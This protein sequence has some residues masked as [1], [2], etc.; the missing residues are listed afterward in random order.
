M[1]ILYLLLLIALAC[2][3]LFLGEEKWPLPVSRAHPIPLREKEFPLTESKSF[4]CVLYAHN[5]A[6]WCE[7]ML[8]SIFDQTHHQYRI[9]FVDDGSV[10]DTYAKTKQYIL[11]HKEESR[12]L[13]LR[14]EEPIGLLASLYRA[15]DYCQE[16]EI[17]LPLEAKDWLIDEKVL[18]R[19]NRIYQNPEIW[20]V[21]APLLDYP[22]YQKRAVSV[23][24]PE[25]AS[26]F[27][28]EL[29]QKIQIKDLF[30]D[31]LL[32]PF[33]T[34]YLTPL[35]QLSEGH[36]A[37]LKEP[38]LF[39]NQAAPQRRSKISQELQAK[40]AL[41]IAKAPKYSPPSQLKAS[42][43]HKSSPDILLFS[44]DRPLQLFAT[45]ESIYRYFIG[46]QEISV[47]YRVSDE[48]FAY[49][50]DKVQQAFPAVRF[51]RQSGSPR[52]D[53][54]PILLKLLFDS[55]S[56][57]I[58]FGVDDLIIKDFADLQFCVEKLESS[59]AYGVYLRFGR[60][61]RS[62]Y[63]NNQPQALPPS[64]PLADG[65]FAWDFRKG[66]SDWGF[67]NNL[68]LTLYRKSDLKDLFKEM[69]YHHPNSLEW[70]WA[71][72]LPTNSVGLY[73]EH[74]KVVNLP[75]NAIGSTSRNMEFL[76]TEELL[77]HFNQ[78]LKIHIDPLYKMENPSPHYEF[79]PEF[80]GR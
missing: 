56:P 41:R 25:T 4:A 36:V 2:A 10:D 7:R 55:P 67:P 38:L 44:F 54:K 3:G 29:M 19:L 71:H 70:E 13:L 79:I 34:A 76:T 75:L 6:P 52:K 58:L 68:D 11:A 46:Y 63:M 49:A 26:S 22:S 47:L 74:S 42:P 35:W 39:S 14:N 31:G 80:I 30:L 33:D 17:I 59:G 15:I 53:F 50:Y 1:R 61:I 5:H 18:S 48:R 27:Y 45:L 57:Y 62:C 12:V 78:G 66:E 21:A 9:I 37:A 40:E 32:S 77:A 65:L 72:H 8:Q 28:A 16:R 51:V 60:H 64:V 20:M 24:H 43:A 23:N 69:K 73:F